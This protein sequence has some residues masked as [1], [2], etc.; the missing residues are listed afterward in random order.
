[1]QVDGQLVWRYAMPAGAPALTA[2][3]G[4]GDGEVVELTG[5]GAG[6]PVSRVV[7]VVGSAHVRGMVREWQQHVA[8]QDV[9][10][11]LTLE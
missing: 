9:S 6:G 5:N 2:P 10:E 1:M 8:Q 4:R 7:G 3:P 11:L